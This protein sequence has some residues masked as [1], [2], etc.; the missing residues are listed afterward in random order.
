M[1]IF[2]YKSLFQFFSYNMKNICSVVFFLYKN[3]NNEA[4]T[5]KAI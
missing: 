2:N 5:K 4:A 1:H 3:E